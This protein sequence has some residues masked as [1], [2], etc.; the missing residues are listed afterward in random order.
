VSEPD[1]EWWWA[2]YATEPLD[3]E[4]RKIQRMELTMLRE[5]AEFKALLKRWTAGPPPKKKEGRPRSK[6]LEA[7]CA[8]VAAEM[9]KGRTITKAIQKAQVLRGQKPRENIKYHR[10]AMNTYFKRNP[11][12][13][14]IRSF[15]PKRA[16]FYKPGPLFA[17]ALE[18]LRRFAETPIKGTFGNKSV[19]KQT[20]PNVDKK[21]SGGQRDFP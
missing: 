13:R 10:V 15:F 11:W 9:A 6:V 8:A 1:E 21:A 14:P 18:Y 12:H 4:G 16:E 17:E 5:Q 20:S 2:D 3:E 7:F 19:P